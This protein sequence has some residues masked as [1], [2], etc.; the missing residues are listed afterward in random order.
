MWSGTESHGLRAQM[1]RAIVDV[2]G[3]VMEGYV[4]GHKGGKGG[5]ELWTCISKR[6]A[7]ELR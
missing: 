2:C 7:D 4:Y 6:W 3:A 5:C 1:N